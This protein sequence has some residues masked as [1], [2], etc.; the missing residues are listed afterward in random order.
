MSVSS[1]SS[2]ENS[3]R[4]GKSAG[5]VGGQKPV[6]VVQKTVTKDKDGKKEEYVVYYYY[7][8]D[9][10]KKNETGKEQPVDSL[11]SFDSDND[12]KTPSTRF[13]PKTISTSTQSGSVSTTSTVAPSVKVVPQETIAAPAAAPAAAAAATTAP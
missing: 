12:S 5:Q 10:D 11:D 9:D 4:Q 6:Q 8:Y 3:D 1:T 7:Y 2:V 13:Q